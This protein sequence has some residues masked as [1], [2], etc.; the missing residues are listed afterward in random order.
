MHDPFG[1][2]LVFAA[3]ASWIIQLL[4]QSKWFPLITTET[5]SLNKL[6]AGFVAALGTAGIL[7]TQSWDG[8]THTLVITLSGLS[9]GNVLMFI[10]H[11][12]GQYIY[13]KGAYKFFLKPST[14]GAAL[15]PAAGA[16]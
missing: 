4:K 7:F 9:A 12:L 6:F 5:Q 11:W 10:W 8:S 1:N 13:M 3:I 14:N 15:P 2:Q 16:K